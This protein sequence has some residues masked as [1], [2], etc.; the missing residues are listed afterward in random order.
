G[1][2]I[3][4]G[5][6]TPGEYGPYRQSERGDFYSK[7]AQQLLDHRQAFYCFCSEEEIAQRREERRE[8][9]ESLHYDGRC[10]HL[11]DDEV[12]R[13][14]DGGEGAVVRFLAP[15]K[16]FHLKDVVRGDVAFPDGMIGDFV[17]MRES[18]MPVYNFCC[19][20]D[21]WKMK[22][23]HVI[24]GEDHLPN[25]VRQLM[26]YQA[27]EVTP[28]IFAHASLLVGEDR[29][30]LSKR[31]G[32]TS[33][34]AFRD[35]SFLPQTMINY[36]VLLGWSHP[37]ERVIMSKD[38]LE[39]IFTLER[40]HKAPALFDLAKMRWMN[41]Q[42]LKLLSPEEQLKVV[43]GWIKADHQF[44]Q[45][46]HQWQMSFLSLFLDKIEMEDDLT[47][48][49]DL[50]FATAPVASSEEQPELEELNALESTGQMRS[51]LAAE[52]SR[53]KQQGSEFVPVE[54]FSG[55]TS[56]FKQELKIKGKP[57]FKGM[58]L[59]LTGRIS[60]GDLSA[61]VPITPIDVLLARVS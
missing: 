17:I 50:I 11:S 30:K 13:R 54:A 39:T 38:E 9:G 24:R 20:I 46:K 45:E 18:G 47:D 1:L 59:I 42:Q 14:R 25:T 36:L 49:L 41:G 7:Y 31:H 12:K 32:V 61:L 6:E 35:L 60:G 52:L 57:L 44:H 21:D 58:R 40:M 19:V 4:E 55:W 23:T 43:T 26:I 34:A 53:L 15:Q 10:R 56:Y 27:L 5:P 48:H 22:I 37:D 33:L 8:K 29:Q 2:E 3:D 51:Y 28:P 16:D